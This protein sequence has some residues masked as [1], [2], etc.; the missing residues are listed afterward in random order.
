[1]PL[2]TAQLTLVVVDQMV[3]PQRVPEMRVPIE[4]VGVAS[5]APKFDPTTVTILPDETG[6][7][8]A[9]RDESTG[10]SKVNVSP[11]VPTTAATLTISACPAPVPADSTH[12]TCVLEPQIELLHGVEP[13]AAVNDVSVVAKFT[14]R[15]VKTPPSL[16]G[17]FGVASNETTGASYVNTSARVPTTVLSV[18]E[19]SSA[20]PVPGLIEQST[21]VDVYQLL[22][23]HE[24]VS[25]KV[26]GVKSTLA[27][28]TPS[29]VTEYAPEA[30][31]FG[32]LTCEVAG[33]SNVNILTE[34]PVRLLLR[35]N[36]KCFEAPLPDLESPLE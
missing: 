32:L 11:F 26:L 6:L 33:A 4:P 22:L 14:P 30:G 10:V 2:A 18:K 16:V 7:F 27:K 25:N 24:A 20:A 35:V 36:T 23:A 31:P 19:T 28:L 12:V 3:V 1:V 13:I 17:R 34:V 9:S 21:L 8:W 5:D 15:M 29:R